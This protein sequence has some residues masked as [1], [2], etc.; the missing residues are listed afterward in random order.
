MVS[1]VVVV[2]DMVGVPYASRNSRTIKSIAARASVCIST[3]SFWSMR[4]FDDEIKALNAPASATLTIAMAMSS[5][6]TVKPRSGLHMR[7]SKLLANNRSHRH[8]MRRCSI[9]PAD[10]NAD[11]HAI[12]QRAIISYSDLPGKIQVRYCNLS[13]G[14][15]LNVCE[16]S[17][18]ELLYLLL[19][20]GY[21]SRHSP[22]QGIAP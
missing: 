21:C 2:V 1:L 19:S 10:A 13:G 15:C 11:G 17:I 6:V 4:R 18:F 9:L 12:V 5:S 3:I 20:Y 14:F 22:R 7:T 16:R 8:R